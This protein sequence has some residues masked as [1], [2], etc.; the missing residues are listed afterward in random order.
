MNQKKK[1][2]VVDDDRDILESITMILT[3]AGYDVLAAT[4]SNECRHILSADKPDLIILD[5][6]LDTMTDGINL[7]MELKADPGSRDIPVVIVSSIEK[8]TGFPL[9][10]KYLGVDDCLEKPLQPKVLLECVNKY[11]S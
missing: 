8:Y 1:I 9:D 4:D 2:L 7:G 10:R 6:M 5:I 3:S 11:I